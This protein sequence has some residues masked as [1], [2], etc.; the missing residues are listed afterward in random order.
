MPKEDKLSPE[1]A[2]LCQHN[3][4][5]TG[6]CSLEGILHTRTN[7]G[8]HNTAREYHLNIT[9]SVTR[10]IVELFIRYHKC[11]FGSKVVIHT[12]NIFF[13]IEYKVTNKYGEKSQL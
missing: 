2:S 7:V 5:G 11:N 6:N 13:L 3:H 1:I 10:N 8:D 12:T 4:Q 9:R